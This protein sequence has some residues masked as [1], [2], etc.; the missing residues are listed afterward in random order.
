M[1]IILFMLVVFTNFAMK[2]KI[3]KTYI[4]LAIAILL[5]ALFFVVQK[6][7]EIKQHSAQQIPDGFRPEMMLRVTPI[8]DQG[9]SELCW[10]YAMLATIETEHLMQE[11]SVNLSVDYLARMYLEEQAMERFLS[12]GEEDINMRGVGPMTIDILQKYGAMPYDSYYTKTPV[13]YIV[14]QR[15]IEKTVDIALS[16]RL[17]KERCLENVRH[18]LDEEIGYLPRYVFMFG[19][20]YS[21]L[22]FAHSVCLPREYK[23]FTSLTDEPYGQEI[24]LPFEDNH[25]H[26]KAMNIE[27]DSLV[28]C[29]EKAL[30]N[31]HP[32]MWEGGS[33]D[34]HAVSII[35]MG[36]D[37]RGEDYY[38]AK[39]SWGKDNPTKGLLYI[40]KEYVKKNTAAIVIKSDE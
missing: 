1:R 25:Y 30:K 2:M 5:V 35:G 19:V 22:E 37:K 34:D 7:D 28:D 24:E 6:Y 32:L 36:K 27:P 10:M 40:K 29:I 13:N 14:L 11:D 20:Q 23:T 8:K 33:N 18:Q 9:K 4:L 15:K 31:G 26:C 16:H 38:V 17:S 12:N 3:R 39:N 21:F